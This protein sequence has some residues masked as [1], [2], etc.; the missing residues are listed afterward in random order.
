MMATRGLAFV[1]IVVGFGLLAA[2]GYWHLALPTGLAVHADTRIEI[3]G[4]GAGEKCDIIVH[5][6]NHSAR[7][8]RVLG[9]TE[10]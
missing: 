9:L 8:V 2:V 10:C 5:V 6:H 1:L 7:P 4:R 3:R